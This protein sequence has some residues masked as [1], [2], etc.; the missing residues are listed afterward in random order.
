MTVTDVTVNIPIFFVC[1]FLFC[2]SANNR[3]YHP[4]Y[5]TNN[6]QKNPASLSAPEFYPHK[7]H[8]SGC[9]LLIGDIGSVLR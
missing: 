6:N 9:V 5:Q 7:M 3:F 2:P 8:A 1:V 4:N